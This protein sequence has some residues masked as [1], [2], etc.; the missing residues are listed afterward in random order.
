[1]FHAGPIGC[2]EPGVTCAVVDVPPGIG[3]WAQFNEPPACGFIQVDITTWQNAVRS[4]NI[5]H[6]TEVLIHEVGHTLGFGHGGYGVMSTLLDKPT[7]PNDEEVAAAR[8][9]WGFS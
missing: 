5:G 3:A 6:L 1:V 7:W 8:A 9:Y 2:P 4:R